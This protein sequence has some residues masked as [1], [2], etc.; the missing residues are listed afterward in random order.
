M[1]NISERSQRS[2]MRSQRMLEEEN[3]QLLREVRFL[4]E[5]S[6]QTANTARDTDYLHQLTLPPPVVDPLDTSQLR[7]SL[8]EPDRLESLT[9]LSQEEDD[10]GGQT[11]CY[12]S[13]KT[14]L[15]YLEMGDIKDRSEKALKEVNETQEELVFLKELTMPLEDSPLIIRTVKENTATLKAVST[16]TVISD[17]NEKD[18][19]KEQKGELSIEK[20]EASK[21][22]TIH[23]QD[24]VEEVCETELNYGVM[25]DNKELSHRVETEG[26]GESDQDGI[27]PEQ[28]DIADRLHKLMM[29][30]EM[31]DKE[32]EKRAKEE[33]QAIEM[34]QRLKAKT[35]ALD[36][37]RER[38]RRLEALKQEE[39][40]RERRLQF[41]IK[42]QREQEERIQIIQQE[43]ER[44]KALEEM[45][46]AGEKRQ[47]I[48][49]LK[50]KEQQEHERKLKFLQQEEERLMRYEEEKQQERGQELQLK[51]KTGEQRKQDGVSTQLFQES[52][53]LVQHHEK[54]DT[55]NV[56]RPKGK[57]RRRD[58]E[59]RCE[60][61]N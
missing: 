2:N 35:A 46:L 19:M 18:N 40:I 49:E 28:K 26:E 33:A 45:K 48:V 13:P 60:R 31:L 22:N 1:A 47:K 24:H 58:L 56:V 6:R 27:D 12:L 55:S 11:A 15:P 50:L 14:T 44:L 59:S 16:N 51:L 30:E 3:R 53:Q 37:E 20:G 23:L 43:G 42:Q 4:R 41:K 36:A 21:R 8:S 5:Q 57:E 29:Q 39:E 54:K 9:Q 25:K 52:E 61:R 38:M 32:N 10:S 34:L 7:G 17:D